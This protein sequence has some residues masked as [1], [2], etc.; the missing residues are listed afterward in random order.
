MN[1]DIDKALTAL[2]DSSIPGTAI[3][4]VLMDLDTMK[5]EGI[6]PTPAQVERKCG[7][8]W[9]LSIGRQNDRKVFFHAHTIHEAFLKARRALKKASPAEREFFGVKIPK[10]RNSYASARRKKDRKKPK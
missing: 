4:R 5:R 8:V 2:E 9:G 7:F 6:K 3:N 1:W 10:K